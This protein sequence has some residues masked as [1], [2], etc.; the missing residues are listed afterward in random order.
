[1]KTDRTLRYIAVMLL[2]L[3]NS[4]ATPT[5]AGEDADRP[6]AHVQVYELEIVKSERKLFVK[7]HGRIKRSF[8]IAV[9]SG[10]YGDKH[11]RG[12]KKTPVGIYQI[13]GFNNNSRFHFFMR[14]NYPNIKD[15]FF[16]LKDRVIGHNEYNRIVSAWRRGHPP[17][18]NTLLGGAIGI[19]G[20]GIEND[21]KLGIHADENWTEGCIALTN[22]EIEDLRRYVSHGTRVVIKE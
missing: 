2:L 6:R 8:N 13:Y 14:L 18:Q 16:G 15:A 10:G 21:E 7:Q 12:D 5:L 19:H 4:I 3:I 11:R 17:P 22:R 9:G 1:M 20:L